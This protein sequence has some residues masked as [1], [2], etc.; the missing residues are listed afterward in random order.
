[1][2]VCKFHIDHDRVLTEHDVKVKR[3]EKDIQ[4][5]YS[6]QGKT[7]WMAISALAGVLLAMITVI[8]DHILSH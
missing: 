2:N 6:L 3:A 8:G 1:M 7:L 4:H 5:L